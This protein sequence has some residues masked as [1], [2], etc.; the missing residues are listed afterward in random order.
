MADIPRKLTSISNVRVPDNE[1]VMTA[2]PR[3]P[4]KQIPLTSWTE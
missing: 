2:G 1:N 4:E 3:G